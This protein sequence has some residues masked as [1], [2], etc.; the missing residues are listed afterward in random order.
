MSNLDHMEGSMG[1][2]E[3][4]VDFTDDLLEGQVIW[5]SPI[6]GHL[7][8]LQNS[9]MLHHMDSKPL[10][11]ATMEILAEFAQKLGA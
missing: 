5:S 7:D 4:I 10:E 3:E 6:L 8:A 2:E 11:G 9:N 1:Y